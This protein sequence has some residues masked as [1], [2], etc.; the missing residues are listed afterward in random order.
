MILIGTMNLTRTHDRG[1]FYCPHCEGDRSYRLRARRPWLTLYFIPTV[2]VG[3][4]EEFV[5]CDSCR[6]SW[7]PTVLAMDRESYQQAAEEEFL[8]QA[9]R[10]SVLVVISDGTIT[11]N[12]IEALK[13]V[14]N[15]LFNRPIDREEL[16]ELCSI[17]KQ[18]RIEACNYVLTVSRAWSPEQRRLALQGMFLA[19]SADGPMGDQQLETLTKMREMLELTS[20]EYQGA[21]EQALEW[22]AV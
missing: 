14:S 18:N 8:E 7:D 4:A 17:A 19:A 3:G 16:G 6:Q 21:I 12:E 13:R 22:D 20:E 5:E 1:D 10:S 2:P 9:M 11:E 15:R